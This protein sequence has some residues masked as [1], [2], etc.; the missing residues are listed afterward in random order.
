MKTVDL[1]STDFEPM[2]LTLTPAAET[3]AASA[4]EDVPGITLEEINAEI[5][6]VR[7]DR[8]ARKTADAEARA[9]MA[10]PEGFDAGAPRRI[11][12]EE[13]ASHTGQAMER[14]KSVLEALAQ[15]APISLTPED[16]EAFAEGLLNPPPLT[17]SMLRA[18][19]RLKT[20]RTPPSDD[21]EA[22]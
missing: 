2:N 21:P 9:A 16:Q 8:A 10:G 7:K 14:F 12:P 6:E 22:Q 13:L 4:D 20:F 15:G 19:E 3:L 17:P 18:L 1:G 11:S 5:R